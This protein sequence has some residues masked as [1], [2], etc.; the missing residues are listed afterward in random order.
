VVY[1]PS[2]QPIFG[3]VPLTLP[4]WELI[5]PLVLVPSVANEA[6]KY[7]MNYLDRRKREAAASALTA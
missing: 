4:E 5:L 2:L 1:V 3:T 7:I 6:Q